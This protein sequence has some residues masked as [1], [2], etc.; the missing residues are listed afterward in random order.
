MSP[1]WPYCLKFETLKELNGRHGSC[2]YNKRIRRKSCE[3]FRDGMMVLNEKFQSSWVASQVDFDL[4]SIDT[5]FILIEKKLLSKDDIASLT[6]KKVTDL[7]L[8][9]DDYEIFYR[10]PQ[11]ARQ[12]PELN[13]KQGEVI[14][15]KIK[16]TK[17][18]PSSQI[19]SRLSLPVSKPNNF[20]SGVSGRGD[21][22]RRKVF[23][24]EDVEEAFT[25]RDSKNNKVD[26][27][28]EILSSDDDFVVPRPKPPKISPEEELRN[29][30]N[31]E[32]LNE[33]ISKNIIQEVV[34]ADVKSILESELFYS[35]LDPTSPDISIEEYDDVFTL[36]RILPCQVKT[37]L[38]ETI[39]EE[40]YDQIL[41]DVAQELIQQTSETNLIQEK[42]KC[43][44]AA[45]VYFI[46]YFNFNQSFQILD[47]QIIDFVVKEKLKDEIK[48]RTQFEHKRRFTRIRTLF[49]DSSRK[50]VIDEFINDS[51]QV[52]IRQEMKKVEAV[53]EEMEILLNE[54]IYEGK[55]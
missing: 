44:I 16:L 12:K 11:L 32:I 13:Y 51:C 49:T 19:S 26:E 7:D 1:I 14:K 9:Q 15:R 34:M 46:L 30:R 8:C 29:K 31:A 24:D 55:F 38:N 21:K 52:F 41:N 48:C 2:C 20:R 10:W 39:A 4:L 42:N 45:E 43:K 53:K 36:P 40:T 54:T 27:V 5:K 37:K 35:D 18:K 17:T 23:Y 50:R 25:F 33:Y 47:T 3:I 22:N 28:I 6:S